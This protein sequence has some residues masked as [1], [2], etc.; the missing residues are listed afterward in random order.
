MKIQR[1]K[2]QKD[3]FL[4]VSI[5][6]KIKEKLAHTLAHRVG[7]KSKEEKERNYRFYG[8]FFVFKNQFQHRTTPPH[9][10]RECGLLLGG[11]RV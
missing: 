4:S 9:L 8:G 10:V 1:K 11:G 2:E 6:K 3:K 5:F 7:K